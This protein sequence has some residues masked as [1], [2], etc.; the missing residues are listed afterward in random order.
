MIGTFTP[1]D[2][3][4]DYFRSKQIPFAR[5]VLA[6]FPVLESILESFNGYEDKP[7]EGTQNYIFRLCSPLLN[8]TINQVA[9]GLLKRIEETIQTLGIMELSKKEKSD[10]IA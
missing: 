3:R 10:F 7:Y 2:P 1:N 6:G 4:P 8:G 9:F 5:K